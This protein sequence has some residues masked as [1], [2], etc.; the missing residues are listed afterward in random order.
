MTKKSCPR[1]GQK[2]PAR[3]SLD[4]EY[5]ICERI[6]KQLNGHFYDKSHVYRRCREHVCADMCKD[7]NIFE[8]AR[9]GCFWPEEPVEPDIHDEQIGHEENMP[10]KFIGRIRELDI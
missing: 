2:C 7:R 8:L 1:K 4:E 10:R 9:C 6:L 3:L 5:P